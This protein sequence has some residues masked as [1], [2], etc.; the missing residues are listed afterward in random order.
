MQH[1]LSVCD[2]L[3]IYLAIYVASHI[4]NQIVGEMSGICYGWPSYIRG[5]HEYNDGWTTRLGQ[6]LE[7][8]VEPTN[9]YDQFA[10]AAIKPDG[11]MVGHIP[12]HQ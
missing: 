7:L 12:K 4:A 1:G 11:T 10:T 9:A 6:M 8:K 5:Y 3:A 2:R